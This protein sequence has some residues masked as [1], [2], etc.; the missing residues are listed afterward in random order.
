[1][2]ENEEAKDGEF[3]M[4]FQPEMRRKVVTWFPPDTPLGEPPKPLLPP[5]IVARAYLN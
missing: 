1:M 2:K 4:L 5:W 3:V